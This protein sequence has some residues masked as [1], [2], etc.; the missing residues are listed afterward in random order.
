MY[1]THILVL[2]NRT[3]ATRS[4]P[5]LTLSYNNTVYSCTLLAGRCVEYRLHLQ[6][7]EPWTT[8]YSFI[9]HAH[10]QRA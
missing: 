6:T 9:Q 1:R 3:V 5:P 7:A 4:L 2:Y 8:Q 10:A